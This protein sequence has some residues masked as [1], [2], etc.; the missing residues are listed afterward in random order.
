VD[1]DVIIDENFTLRSDK[2]KLESLIK[3]LESDLKLS[4][5]SHQSELTI[6]KTRCEGYERQVSGCARD[7]NEAKERYMQ[8]LDALR[9]ESDHRLSELKDVKD[10]CERD[11]DKL[12]LQIEQLEMRIRMMEEVGESREAQI[13]AGRSHQEELIV[14]F[15]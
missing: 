4:E 15:A 1:L 8:D 3:K 6:L 10:R 9:L 5:L 14:Q 7:L 2:V 11:N 13:R 12:R